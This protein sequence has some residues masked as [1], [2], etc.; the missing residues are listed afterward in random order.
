ME[1]IEYLEVLP[2]PLRDEKW[3]CEFVTTERLL[4]CIGYE[5]FT[6]HF[7][8]FIWFLFGMLTH[9]YFSLRRPVPPEYLPI[10]AEA[11]SRAS[12]REMY[13]DP[14]EPSSLCVRLFLNFLCFICNIL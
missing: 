14:E 13:Q 12:Y 8:F 3:Y 2:N 10:I 6:F 11:E 1:K 5:T 9:R 7:S 4:F